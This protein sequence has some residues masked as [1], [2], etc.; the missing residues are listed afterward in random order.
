MNADE[1][2]RLL[3]QLLFGFVIAAL[4]LY[5]S[6]GFIVRVIKDSQP[7]RPRL[8]RGLPRGG[9]GYLGFLIGV[10]ALIAAAW[11]D[12]P[13][14]ILAAG[15][16]APLCLWMG[17]GL[18]SDSRHGEA[19]DHVVFEGDYRRGAGYDRRAGYRRSEHRLS[20][21]MI[22]L[23]VASLAVAVWRHFRLG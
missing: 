2:D 22:L 1:R 15:L 19:I 5:R 23:G 20:N 10:A 9:L 13:A 11:L 18:R 8:E 17:L 3:F 14:A 7:L 21:E 4:C 6:V 16:A 12:G